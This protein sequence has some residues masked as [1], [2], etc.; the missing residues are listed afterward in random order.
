MKG[1]NN[2]RKAF[3]SAFTQLLVLKSKRSPVAEWFFCNY[4]HV[5]TL[6]KLI[7]D[8]IS[9]LILGLARAVNNLHNNIGF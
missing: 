6:T 7:R 2:R 5:M 4:H 8:Y 3:T 1:L 9:V